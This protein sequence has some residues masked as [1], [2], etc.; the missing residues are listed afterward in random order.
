LSSILKALKKLEDDSV[1]RD[2]VRPLL[3][4]SIVKGPFPSI[5]GMPPFLR[6]AGI[7]CAVGGL[8]L[9][10]WYVYGNLSGSDEIGPRMHPSVE[11]KATDLAGGS[12]VVRGEERLAPRTMAQGSPSGVAPGTIVPPDVSTKVS[13]A[14]SDPFPEKMGQPLPAEGALGRREDAAGA[15][16]TPTRTQSFVPP[17]LSPVNE[18]KGDTRLKLQAIAWSSDPEKRIAVINDRVVRE[19]RVIDGIMVDRIDGDQVVVQEDGEVWRI[20]FDMK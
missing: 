8:A 9:G 7:A 10:G 18:R 4:R 2:A 1:Q 13:P 20:V 5:M 11:R 14:E 3:R 17:E 6:T 15:V 12:A 16:N 19:G